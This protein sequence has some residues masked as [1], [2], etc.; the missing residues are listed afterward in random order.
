MGVQIEGKALIIRMNVRENTRARHGHIPFTHT[1]PYPMAERILVLST[2][3][4]LFISICM[5][6]ELVDFLFDY[7]FIYLFI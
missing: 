7:L 4:Y 3:I 1:L 6:C 2:Y 5:L